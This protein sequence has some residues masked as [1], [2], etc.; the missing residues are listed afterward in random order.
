MTTMHELRSIHELEALLSQAVG[1]LLQVDSAIK[2]LKPPS[3]KR[4]KLSKTEI[5]TAFDVARIN[6]RKNTKR[7]KHVN[8]R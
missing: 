6:A 2:A 4:K 5:L 8:A 7:S 1:I 3:P